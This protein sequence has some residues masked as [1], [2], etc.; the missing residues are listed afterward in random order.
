M[1]TVADVEAAAAFYQRVFG[2]EPRGIMTGPD[3]QAIHV[4]LTLRGTHI[5]L[6]PAEHG[7]RT[8]RDI[9]RTP[10]TLYLMVEDVD[11]TMA[12]AADAGGIRVG[13]VRE[14]FW[15]SRRGHII[16]PDGH[17]WMVATHVADYS[18][19]QLRGINVGFRGGSAA[20]FPAV[21]DEVS[22]PPPYRIGL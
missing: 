16:D 5:M 19:E 14:M 2:F 13:E 6:T 1:L 12:L 10:V 4:E 21:Q 8:A 9:G 20:C 15:G 7:A 22:N 3:G 11:K 18:L 17:D